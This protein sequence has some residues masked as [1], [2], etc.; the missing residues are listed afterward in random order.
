MRARQTRLSTLNTDVLGLRL[1]LHR[2]RRLLSLVK[3]REKLKAQVAAL[4]QAHFEIAVKH[5][6]AGGGHGGGGMSRS[7]AMG[8]HGSAN[9]SATDL[10]AKATTPTP[11]EVGG[12]DGGDGGGDDGGSSNRRSSRGKGKDRAEAEIP[13]I[14]P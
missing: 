9:G 11:P 8:G 5:R 4:H 13:I 12:G 2:M 3:R 6:K 7:P 14:Y 1:H 10:A